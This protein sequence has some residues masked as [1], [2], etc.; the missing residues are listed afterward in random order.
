VCVG[1]RSAAETYRS[2]PV[3]TPIDEIAPHEGEP[4]AG[5]DHAAALSFV[6]PCDV[7]CSSLLSL[8]HARPSLA[9]LV[10]LVRFPR[11]V[12]L[13]AE[14]GINCERESLLY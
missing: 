2:D 5:Q 3:A 6:D 7:D 14:A 12:C 4:R 10:S 8:S 13:E 11:Q 1:V 9:R